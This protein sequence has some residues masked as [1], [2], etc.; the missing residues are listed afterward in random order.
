MLLGVEGEGERA[1]VVGA[2]GVH[3]FKDTAKVHEKKVKT[4]TLAGRELTQ[5]W[6]R[7]AES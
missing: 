7:G 4:T 3:A 2:G 6:F 1:W 5:G